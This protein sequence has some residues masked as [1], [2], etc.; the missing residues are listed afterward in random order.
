MLSVYE[1]NSQ[2]RSH[3]EPHT[4]QIPHRGNDPNLSFESSKVSTAYVD[5]YLL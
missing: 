3:V 1:K 2:N 5:T 4:T